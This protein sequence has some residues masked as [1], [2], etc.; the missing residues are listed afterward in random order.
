MKVHW[1]EPPC[2]SL[3]TSQRFGCWYPGESLSCFYEPAKVSSDWDEVVFCSS[4]SALIFITKA[5]VT[6]G[7]P[8]CQAWLHL[9]VFSTLP[10]LCHSA[11]VAAQAQG[12]FVSHRG[13]NILQQVARSHCRAAEKRSRGAEPTAWKTLVYLWAP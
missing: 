5:V 11:L 8:Q 9:L 12:S 4:A 6:P 13:P 10:L 2:C 7:K 3:S 1:R